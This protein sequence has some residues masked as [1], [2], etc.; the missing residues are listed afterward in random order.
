MA[1]DAPAD[2]VQVLDPSATNAVPANSVAQAPAASSR[3]RQSRCS[4]ITPMT[5]NG[6]LETTFQK[7]LMPRIGR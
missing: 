6:R 3:L 4:P 2:A 7:W 1:R 5:R